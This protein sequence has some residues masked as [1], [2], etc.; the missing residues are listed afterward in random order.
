MALRV[1]KNAGLAQREMIAASRPIVLHVTK[2]SRDEV[3][4]LRQN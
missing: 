1:Y 2:D 3:Q 4:N